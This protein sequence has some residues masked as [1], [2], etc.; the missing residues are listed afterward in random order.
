MAII[1]GADGLTVGDI[2]REIGEDSRF[3]VY[4]CCISIF[5]MSFK[6]SSAIHFVRPGQR[7]WR[8]ALAMSG[9][10]LVVGWWGIP[11]GP[12][13]TVATVVNN[14][15][16]GQDV[17]EE[18]MQALSGY[19]EDTRIAPRGQLAELETVFE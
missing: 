2:F 8:P 11:W 9:V 3:V 5:V 4:Q 1:V 10:S 14:L 12:I 16:G 6:K 18:M 19:T 17:T 13:W 15:S 7:K